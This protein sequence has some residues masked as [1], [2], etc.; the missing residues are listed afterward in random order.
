MQLVSALPAS[1]AHAFAAGCTRGTSSEGEVLGTG[2]G[3]ATIGGDGGASGEGCAGR[4]CVGCTGLGT[5]L[6]SP[7]PPGV[8]GEGC[9]GGGDAG[10]TGVMPDGV[11]GVIPPGDTGVSMPG[12]VPTGAP[13][14]VVA[15]VAAG[16]GAATAAPLTQMVARPAKKYLRIGS[17]MIVSLWTPGRSAIDI[18]RATRLAR[19]S[20]PE[21]ARV[22]VACGP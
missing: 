20:T 14:A 4:G 22:G 1:P 6:T 10:E 3:G 7:T 18:R 2:V 9:T 5:A 17:C 16:G 12:G 15:T 19:H 11:T 21:V 8:T 13:V